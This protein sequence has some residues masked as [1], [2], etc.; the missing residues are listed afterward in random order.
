M[1]A[2]ALALT[3]VL[4][5]QLFGGDDGADGNNGKG[6]PGRPLPRNSS[7]FVGN[8]AGEV[9]GSDGAGFM[10]FVRMRIGTGNASGNS[11]TYSF[12]RGGQGIQGLEQRMCRGTI[13]S[14]PVS[15]D[16]MVVKRE[17]LKQAEVVADRPEDEVL[18]CQPPKAQT[19]TRKGDE[20]HW[21][22]GV[23]SAVLRD[24]GDEP[25]PRAIS[26]KYIGTWTSEDV[27][28][29][30]H[31]RI[32][33]VELDSVIE[34]TAGTSPNECYVTGRLIAIEEGSLSA[35]L[36]EGETVAQGVCA[37]FGSF[38][39]RSTGKSAMDVQAE[40]YHGPFEFL[41]TKQ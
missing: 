28:P 13:G 22:D 17:D 36:I 24:E 19:L 12:L 1:L 41:R 8:W 21:R 31:L 4:L 34:I 20:L 5:P 32:E 14:V 25:T 11:G 30:Y 33:E 3:V 29:N 38:T 39:L 2:T 26:E 9:E 6:G 16:R 23:Q 15:G 40:G 7:T 37:D 10:R 27:S 18:A 35:G